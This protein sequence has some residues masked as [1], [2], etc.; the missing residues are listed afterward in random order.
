MLYG[1]STFTLRLPTDGP[2]PRELRRG[3]HGE[4][5]GEAGRTLTSQPW[6][7]QSRSRRSAASSARCFAA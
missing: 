2:T 6:P 1:G 5:Q 3:S 7:R 4:A